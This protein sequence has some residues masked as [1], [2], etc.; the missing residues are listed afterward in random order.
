MINVNIRYKGKELSTIIPKRRQE[1]AEDIKKSGINLPAEKLKLR[2][3]ANDQYLVGLYTNNPLDDLIIDRLCKNDNLFE[4]NNLCEILDNVAD[5]DVIFKTILYSDA[6]CIN[7]IKKLFADHFMEFSD[8]LVLNTNLEEKPVSF[9]VKKCVIEKAIAVTHK[10]FEHISRFPFM[11]V[12]FIERNKDFMYY[13]NKENMYHCILLYDI[14][15]GDGIVI[16]SEGSSY[17]RYA[18][19]VPQAKNI[20][21]QFLDSHLNEIRLCCPIAI[22]RHIKDYSKDNCILV[23]HDSERY[24]LCEKKSGKMKQ[25]EL[26]FFV[27]ADGGL[28][29]GDADV[30]VSIH[31]IN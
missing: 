8:K 13:D 22:Y 3:N 31:F 5:H 28:S 21:E 16:E 11:N 25:Y 15:F 1:L 23:F 29:D 14:D 12:A 27:N 19:Y 17:T 30:Y 10:N 6:R 24:F 7:G 4:L 9:D 20:Y 2:N 26:H 18:Q